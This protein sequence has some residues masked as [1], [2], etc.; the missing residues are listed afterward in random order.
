VPAEAEAP[1]EAEKARPN[2]RGMGVRLFEAML[3][4][5]QTG[6][7][8]VLVGVVYGGIAAYYAGAEV[9]L[10]A[11][12]GGAKGGMAG[13]ALGVLIAAAFFHRSAYPREE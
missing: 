4:V 10:E 12:I 9:P 3:T 11:A 8:G 5:L 1:R 2:R 6:I 13:L 7:V